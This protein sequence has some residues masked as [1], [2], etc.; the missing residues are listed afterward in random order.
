[1]SRD[2]QAEKEFCQKI[3][4][5]FDRLV[6]DRSNYD[7]HCHEIAQ[8][9]IPSHSKLFLNGGETGTKGEK[10]NENMI[11]AKAAIAAP[12]FASI[13]DSLLTPRQQIWQK[14]TTDN[15]YL[16]KNREVKAYFEEVTQLLFSY[17]YAAEANFS[18]QNSLNYLSISGYG[19]ACMFTDNLRDKAKGGLR[20]KSV[21]LSSVYW[22]ENH[23]GQVDKAFRRISMKLRQ[24]KQRFPEAKLPEKIAKEKD[25]DKEF[26]VVHAVMPREDYDPTRLDYRGK[27]YASCYV[28]R[29]GPCL[30]EEGG[31]DTFPF[32]IPRYDQV[33]G[34]VTGRGPAMLALPAIKTANE[35]KRTLLKQGQRATDLILL[36]HDD[37]VVDGFSMKPGAIN[38]GGVNAD[39]RPLVHALPVGNVNVGK[40]ML[41]GEHNIIDDAFLISLFQILVENPMMSATEVLERAKEKGI[42]L[43][44]TIGRL[45]TEYLSPMV[46]REI[47]CLR[48]QRLLPEMP[49]AL[50]E[51]E[52]EYT[53]IYDSPISRAQRAEQAAGIVRTVESTL[54][55]VNVTKDPSPLDHFDF[56]VIT[57]DLADINGVPQRWM[58]SMEKIQQIREGR[59]ENMQNEQLIKAG[60][61][62]AAVMK[63]AQDAQKKT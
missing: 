50:I 18:G 58:R 28:L 48:S 61:A 60:P 53:I 9:V 42:L 43:V 14:V 2:E 24:I 21:H 41:D 13:I 29:D 46:M 17:R 12:R 52:G 55:I 25:T 23:Q 16:M 22:D 44:P 51:A 36:A 56:D 30:L 33:P 45:Q 8:R 59:T 54:A 32:S 26:Q 40:D 1:M 34:E 63:T 11:D 57:P 19:G 38:A 47:D 35:I 31:Y 39:G 15:P 10:R 7:S 3:L 27:P 37:G 20:Y 62:A 5:D 49:E 4:K 6:T